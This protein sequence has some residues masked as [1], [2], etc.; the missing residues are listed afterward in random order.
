MRE[1]LQVKYDKSEKDDM[2]DFIINGKLS[3]EELYFLAKKGGFEDRNLYFKIKEEGN[4]MSDTIYTDNVMS[5]GKGWTKDTCIMT[6]KYKK[7]EE[8]EQCSG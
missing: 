5:F 3:I 6:I 1:I 2:G 4:K 8:M 7:E